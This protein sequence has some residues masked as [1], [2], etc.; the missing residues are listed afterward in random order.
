ME[1]AFVPLVTP[2]P[3]VH[4]WAERRFR[5]SAFDSDILRA[6]AKR[7]ASAGHT[8]WLHRGRLVPQCFIEEYGVEEAWRLAKPTMQ[9]DTTT[10]PW[11]LEAV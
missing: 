9:I 10:N 11:T 4:F 2:L 3:P 6:W 7:T 5:A 8:F 1:G